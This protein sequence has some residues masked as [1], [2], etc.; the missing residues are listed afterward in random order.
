M[1]EKA[2]WSSLAKSTAPVCESFLPEEQ[3]VSSH[4]SSLPS[5]KGI[6]SKTASLLLEMGPSFSKFEIFFE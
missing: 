6:L 3:G 1:A 2:V 5:S 4:G